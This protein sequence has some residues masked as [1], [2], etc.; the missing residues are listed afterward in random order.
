VFLC[1]VAV[2]VPWVSAKPI[3]EDQ[4]PQELV[5]VGTEDVQVDGVIMVPE[6][7]VL[8]PVGVAG[9]EEV[10]D[11]FERSH[12]DVF[13]CRVGNDEVDVHPVLRCQSG[14]GRRPD[15]LIARTLAPSAARIAV[16]SLA[17]VLGHSGL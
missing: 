10:A 3:S 17:N 11:G 8:I 16:S 4:V 1:R 15:V 7:A 5:A 12:I 2:A 14:N 9:A 13:V 6:A